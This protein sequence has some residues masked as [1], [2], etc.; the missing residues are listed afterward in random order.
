[1]SVT[2]GR[3]AVELKDSAGIQAAIN[4][5]PRTASGR[6]W[7]GTGPRVRHGTGRPGHGRGRGRERRF[8]SLAEELAGSD[9]PDRRL[10]MRCLT[11]IPGIDFRHPER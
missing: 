5:M 3:V 1:M 9:R 6:P 2:D 8:S 4:R 10:D 11:A 7:P